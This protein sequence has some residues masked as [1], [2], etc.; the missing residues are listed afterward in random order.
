MSNHFVIDHPNLLWAFLV[1][2]RIMTCGGVFFIL[3][4]MHIL[5]SGSIAELI[6]AALLLG[7]GTFVLYPICVSHVNDKIE[8]DERVEACGV[9]LMLQSIGMI[10]GP[11]TISFLMQQFGSIFFLISLSSVS[12][13]F[14]LFSLKH[15]SFKQ[16][17]GYKT[18]TPTDPMPLAPTHVF[19]ELAKNDTILD[20]AKNIF[21]PKNKD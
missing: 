13:F 16:D 17:V 19:S 6:P 5:I 14:V 9:L 4:W 8:D 7:S 18:I 1:Y 21:M 3:P 10:I 2:Y 20:K 15:I 12:G 11:I